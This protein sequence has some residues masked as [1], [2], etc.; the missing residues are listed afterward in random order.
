MAEKRT[1]SGN[2]AADPELRSAPDGTQFA[3]FPVMENKRYRDPET[4]EWKDAKATRY[5]VTVD[6]AKLRDNIMA[7]LEKGQRVAVNGNYVPKPFVDKKTGEQR[8]GHKLYAHDVAASYMH[9]PQGRGRIA[10]GRDVQPEVN[11]NV[12]G[13][14][15][16]QGGAPAWGT[17]P[18]P[19][20]QHSQRFADRGQ[21]V[22]QQQQSYA[23]PS[24][25]QTPDVGMDR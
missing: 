15:V 6:N 3:A 20:P 10:P 1:I 2:V 5:E 14:G 9:E 17:A 25:D 23:P 21:P 22:H 4:N 12:S 13:P 19:Y 7:S 8:V 24:P 16:E 18:D 11:Q